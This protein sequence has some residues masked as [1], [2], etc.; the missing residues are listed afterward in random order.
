MKLV[1]SI[2]LLMALILLLS[3]VGVYGT[4]K[5]ADK[6]VLTV[7]SE[8]KFDF[9]LWTGS[10]ILPEEDQ[11]GQNHLALIEA[12][13]NGE[14]IGL[15]T[16]GSYLNEEI[17]DRK[18]RWQLGG[19]RDTLGSVAVTQGEDLNEL[20]SLKTQNLHFL[21]HF[22]NQ[23]NTNY[24][25]YTTAVDFGERGTINFWGNNDEP[26][27]PNIPIGEYIYPIYQTIV[28]KENGVWVA[29]ETNLGS[30]K[31]A[32][33]E[34]SRSNA[35]ATQIP[36]FDP[37]TWVEGERG[38]SASTAIWTYIGDSTTAI[39]S[40]ASQPLYYQIKPSSAGNLAVKVTDGACVI[41]VYTSD[42]VPVATS[43]RKTDAVGSSYSEVTW[44]AS[45]NTLYY[46]TFEGVRNPTYS[47][48]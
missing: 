27:K 30:A 11:V 4:W 48:S 22:P 29:K 16:S 8:L 7:E 34:E 35:N 47:V 44:S 25:I 41:K 5:Y 6:P 31:S 24:E 20:F 21:I 19:A 28:V 3:V 40:Q 36:S 14:G 45:A 33:Y 17:K 42:H 15:N 18:S 12:I 46:I 39:Q 10:D 9:L 2:T 13:I 38:D 26:G 23:N 37:D 43:V 1:R 32:W